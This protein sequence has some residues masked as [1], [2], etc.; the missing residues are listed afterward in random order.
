MNINTNTNTNISFREIRYCTV[1]WPPSERVQKDG[2]W[3]LRIAISHP[4]ELKDVKTDGSGNGF[5]QR[6]IKVW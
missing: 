5:D 3:S 4:R 2:Y 1:R 6:L